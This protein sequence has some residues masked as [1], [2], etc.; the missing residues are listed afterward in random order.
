V[1]PGLQGTDCGPWALL[2]RG[3]ELAGGD[4]IYFPCRV[5]LEYA[6]DGSSDKVVMPSDRCPLSIGVSCHSAP[7]GR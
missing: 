7:L 3:S 6:I 4:N 1:V 5:L 2:R